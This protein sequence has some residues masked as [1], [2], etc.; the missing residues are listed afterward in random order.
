MANP[1][2]EPLLIPGV[3][4]APGGRL[5]VY[6]PFDRSGL[7]EV[8][9]ADAAAL[10][11]A[12]ATADRL[13]RDPAA[14]LP[15]ELRL[16]ALRGAAAALEAEAESWAQ[17]IAE[18]G[19][20]PLRDA[21]VEVAR[22]ADSLRACAEALR[23]EAGREV[24]M[25]LNPASS[26]RWAFTRREPIGPV[27][28]FSAFN[29]PL[30][31]IVHQAGPALAAGCPVVVKPAETTPLTAFR[32][33][34]LLHRHGIPPAWAQGV[35]VTDLDL[36]ARLAADPRVALFNFIGSDAVGWRLRARLA[37]GTRCLLEHGGTAPVIVM[38]DADLDVLV[39]ALVRG[40]FYHAG[41]VCVSVQRVLA[42]GN[43][44]RD[45][46]E[47][48]AAAA[49]RLVVGD[50]RREGTDVGPLIRP[51]ALARLRTL[52]AEAQ[53]GGA[54]VLTGGESAGPTTFAPTVL[55][56]P[57][58]G[59]RVVTEEVFGPVVSVLPVPD[60]DR[61][62]AAANDSPF[63]FQA[64]I[65]T[66]DLAAALRAARELRAAAVLVNDPT[67]FRVDW[68]PFGGRG[69]SALGEGGIPFTYRAC[70]PEKLVVLRS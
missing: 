51:A 14:R 64:S 10:E 54:E 8:A 40:A 50:P 70:A 20:K 57:P 55:W 66:R 62:L 31:L 43:G 61:A 32:F 22:A 44:A 42:V 4:G 59:G 29:H 11:H 12:L 47:R 26:G 60:L 34:R 24:P 6:R 39:P 48:L 38:P 5:T 37:P 35:T 2:L 21:R 9:A 28:A 46:A 1:D 3:A 58:P 30:N 63:A 19:G 67:T 68:M 53:T 65:F 18:E 17:G 45:L 36:A 15:A 7:A 52:V 25:D 56:N 41:Q 49:A 16:H 69:R 33:L 13:A 23:T 27:L